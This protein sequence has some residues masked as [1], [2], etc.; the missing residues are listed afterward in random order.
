[1]KSGE[2]PWQT[3]KCVK[4]KARLRVFAARTAPR[5]LHKEWEKSYREKGFRVCKMMQR[6][7]EGENRARTRVADYSAR[8]MPFQRHSIPMSIYIQWWEHS[9]YIAC[10]Y[11]HFVAQSLSMGPSN[12]RKLESLLHMSLP[13]KIKSQK[14][15]TSLGVKTNA[16]LE[17]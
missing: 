8:L 1:V 4:D 7:G 9:C 2:P 3:H 6:P 14:S 5:T 13:A 15:T 12:D 11:V 16:N 17:G 10:L